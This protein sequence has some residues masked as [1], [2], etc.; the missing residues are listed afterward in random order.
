MIYEIH[1]NWQQ[2]V[3]WV[4]KSN[5]ITGGTKRIKKIMKKLRE[6]FFVLV[7]IFGYPRLKFDKFFY[8]AGHPNILLKA[9]INKYKNKFHVCT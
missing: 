5:F 2:V 8:S 6:A 7:N 1:V 3:G 4:L 9:D